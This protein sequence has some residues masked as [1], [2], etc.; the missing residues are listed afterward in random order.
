MHA[1]I[2]ETQIIFYEQTYNF[3]LCKYDDY[4]LLNISLRLLLNHQDNVAYSMKIED[5]QRM[6]KNNI[7]T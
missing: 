2:V 6:V 3:W 5:V 7:S 1:G 4:F